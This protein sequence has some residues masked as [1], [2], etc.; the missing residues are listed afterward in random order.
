MRGK[1][2]V[3]DT[4]IVIGDHDTR[5]TFDIEDVRRDLQA[6]GRDLHCT[7]VRIIG[8]NPDR[9][10]AAA[11]EAVAAGLEVWFSPFT[12]DLSP[13][14]LLDLYADCAGRIKGSDMVFVAGAEHSLLSR[15]F[16]PGDTIGDRVGLL[17]SP[18]TL[19][20]HLGRVPALVNAFLE[21]AVTVVRERF[22]GRIT[23][24][25]IPFESV[26]WSPFDIV[27]VDL[28]RSAEIA[29]RYRDGV[30]ELVA[31]SGKPVAITE[32]GCMTFR[33]AGDLGARGTEVV[34]YD[35]HRPAGLSRPLARD[36]GEQAAYLGEVLDVCE[37]E[38][39]DS[40]FVNTFAQ[41][42]M[43]GELDAASYGIVRVTGEGSWEPKQAFRL[44][45]ER[46]R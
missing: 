4:G 14:E 21:D 3:Y 19:R 43:P 45:A 5:E 1:G 11:R 40:V 27:G 12:A 8:S 22:A 46:Y 32:V 44:L 26:D 20:R 39:V 9:L 15:G 2:I 42:D 30:R 6:I 41:H 24:A 31:R 16:L 34:R 13:A 23:Y 29:D 28:Y 10:E 7:A 35:G 36:E 18:E 38:G 33:N 37:Q 25:A 17:S